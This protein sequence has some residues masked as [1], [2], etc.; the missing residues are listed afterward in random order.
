[1]AMAHVG[2]VYQAGL[3]MVPGACPAAFVRAVIVW[4]VWSR[5]INRCHVGLQGR[6]GKPLGSKVSAIFNGKLCVCLITLQVLWPHWPLQ[7]DD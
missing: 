6:L 3:A 5:P 2:R 1:M 7:R 4:R